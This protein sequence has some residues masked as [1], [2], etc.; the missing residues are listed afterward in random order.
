MIIRLFWEDWS[1]EPNTD[2]KA[3]GSDRSQAFISVY[4]KKFQNYQSPEGEVTQISKK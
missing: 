1:E 3:D 2:T 4:R